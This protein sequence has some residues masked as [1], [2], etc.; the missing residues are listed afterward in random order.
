VTLRRREFLLSAGAPLLAAAPEKNQAVA[1]AYVWTQEMKKRGLTLEQGLP[2]IFASTRRAGFD[3]IELMSDFFA[4]ALRD[5]T[6][7]EL[8]KSGLTAPVVYFGGNLHDNVKAASTCKAALALA[9]AVRGAGTTALNHNPDPKPQ[10]AVKEEWE[11]SVQSEWLDYIGGQLADRGMGFLVHHHDAEMA[12]DAGEWKFILET[13]NPETVSLCVDTHWAYR[14]GQDPLQLLQAAGSRV[15]SIH[16]RNSVNKVWSEDFAN[17]DVD[18]RPVAAWL[19]KTGLKPYLV[20]ELAQE[21]G[22]MI[23]RSLE[24]NLGRSRVYLRDVFGV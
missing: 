17:G 18:Y 13:T 10:K 19:K 9:E 22:Q 3:Q 23:T 4:P 11:L 20:V 5:R 24:E 8:R 12:D 6:L 15:G 21:N 14:G 16:L 2:E 1:Q 7:A